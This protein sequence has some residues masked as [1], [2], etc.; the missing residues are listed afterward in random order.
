MMVWRCHLIDFMQNNL[1]LK[2]WKTCENA[3]VEMTNFC[4]WF[5]QRFASQASELPPF[6]CAEEGPAG[7]FRTCLKVSI[8]HHVVLD[9]YVLATHSL[10]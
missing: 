4:G 6:P 10:T 8:G 5:G 3:T 9:L 1:F 7:A 2:R